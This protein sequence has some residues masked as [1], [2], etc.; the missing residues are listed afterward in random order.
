MS[1]GRYVFIL[2]TFFMR[3]MLQ[4][5]PVVLQLLGAG[6]LPVLEELVLEGSWGT[7]SR[8]SV[9]TSLQLCSTWTLPYRRYADSYP[10]LGAQLNYWL[11][12]LKQYLEFKDELLQVYIF[13]CNAHFFLPL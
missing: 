9:I 3:L 11:F 4:A 12:F 6:L 1:T 5:L 10:A 2:G 7:C 8:S 13:F